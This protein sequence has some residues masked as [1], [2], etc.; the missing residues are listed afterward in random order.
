MGLSHTQETV[1]HEGESDMARR[2]HQIID[3]PEHEGLGQCSVCRGAEGELPTEC[4]GR[5]MT[6][7]ECDLV[8]SGE[9]EFVRGCW[10]KPV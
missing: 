5:P 2:P 1:L 6:P 10:W 4:P 8:F 9:L 3:V 7:T